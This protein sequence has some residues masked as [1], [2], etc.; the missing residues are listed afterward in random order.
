MAGNLCVLVRRIIYH[1]DTLSSCLLLPWRFFRSTVSFLTEFAT[2]SCFNDSLHYLLFVPIFWDI[3]LVG[4]F[5][6]PLLDFQLSLF[7]EG[8]FP[9]GFLLCLRFTEI[10]LHF[11]CTCSLVPNMA[12]LSRPI[13]HFIL[14]V[15]S[16]SAFP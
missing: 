13:L 15:V 14:A 11:L 3:P 16:L 5:F 6:S 2:S 10:A 8:F 4:G 9:L 7:G 1:I 12:F